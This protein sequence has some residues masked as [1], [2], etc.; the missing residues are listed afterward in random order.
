MQRVHFIGSEGIGMSAVADIMLGQGKCVSG[1]DL[2]PGKMSQALEEK[3]AKIY[4]GHSQEHLSSEVEL[5][6][7]SAAIKEENPEIQQARRLNIPVIKYAESL[8]MLMKGKKGIA[9]A[10]TH[11]KSTTSGM[12]AY[13]LY[14]A[15]L[16]PSFVVGAVLRQFQKNSRAGQ[17]EYFVAEACEYD[18]SYLQLHPHIAI[19]TNMEADHLDYYKDIEEIRDSF[20]TFARLLPKDGLLVIEQSAFPHIKN[21]SCPIQT[22]SISQKADWQALNIRRENGR[23]RFEVSHKGEMKGTFEISLYGIHNVANAL[24]VIAVGYHLGIT[25]PLLQK[26]IVEYE[27]VERRFEVLTETPV[28]IIDDY[29]H[30]PTKIKAVLNALRDYRE[31]RKVWCVFQPHQASRTYYLLDEFAE[32]FTKADEIIVTDIFYARDSMEIRQKVHSKDLVA[33]IQRHGQRAQY[34]SSFGEIEEFLK[35]NLQPGDAVL[36]V[37]AGSITQLSQQ[38][39]SM[40]IFSDAYKV[41][42]PALME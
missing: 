37:G 26:A 38:L 12:A 33:K 28:T 40:D 35:K 2:N 21:I 11:G 16:D 10:G 42:S 5:V 14:A 19:I 34:I 29:A 27:G 9:V 3:G 23:Y 31:F 7:A 24:A 36:L 32:A 25:T 17:G 1:S 41:E 39:A 30:H 22:Y 20:N 15:H 18:R 4:K 13:M 6:I 8:G